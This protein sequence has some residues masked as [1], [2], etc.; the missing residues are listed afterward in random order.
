MDRGQEGRSVI[1]DRKSEQIV[2]KLNEKMFNR[3]AGVFYHAIDKVTYLLNS[4]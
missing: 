4:L 2:E 3:I 1:V